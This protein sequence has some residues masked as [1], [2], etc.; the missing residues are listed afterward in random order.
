MYNLIEENKNL[1]DLFMEYVGRILSSII[2][3]GEKEGIITETNS[4][5]YK[6]SAIRCT[7]IGFSQYVNHKDCYKD[8][9]VDVAKDVAYTQLI[10]MLR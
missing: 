7:F 5:Y 8:V 4:L 10:K 9:G 3:S 6:K 2:N 1:I